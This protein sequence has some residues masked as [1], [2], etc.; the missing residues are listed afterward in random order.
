MPLTATNAPELIVEAIVVRV[1]DSASVDAASTG[2][3]GALTTNVIACSV[4]L[5][6]G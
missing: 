1:E 3:G 2:A 5:F 6:V 4:L